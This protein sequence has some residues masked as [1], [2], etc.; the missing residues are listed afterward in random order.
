MRE[1]GQVPQW[2]RLLALGAV[3]MRLNRTALS[4]QRGRRR[5]GALEKQAPQWVLRRRQKTG[6]TLAPKRFSVDSTAGPALCARNILTRG[7]S[8]LDF[9]SHNHHRTTKP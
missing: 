9:C 5:G 4:G 6:S 3:G 1:K 2:H 8:G 7:S